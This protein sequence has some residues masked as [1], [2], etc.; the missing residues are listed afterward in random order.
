MMPPS[1]SDLKSTKRWWRLFFEPVH[2]VYADDAQ[3]P[4]LLRNF[5]G[6]VGVIGRDHNQLHVFARAE[7]GRIARSRVRL[8]AAHPPKA[9]MRVLRESPGRSNA[10]ARPGSER[11]R[12]RD[13]CA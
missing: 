10:S 6:P 11:D 5:N 13:C 3:I 4:A 8:S 1:M 2:A 7:L 12:R 9:A